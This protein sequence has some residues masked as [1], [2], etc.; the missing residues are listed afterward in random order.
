MKLKQV[1]IQAACAALALGTATVAFAGTQPNPSPASPV[2]VGGGASLPEFLYSSEIAVFGPNH[3]YAVTGSGGGKTALTTNNP[4]AFNAAYVTPRTDTTV[5]YAGSDSILSSSDISAFAPRK[6]TDGALVQIPSVGTAVGIPFQN[7]SLSSLTLNDDQLC[8]VFSGQIT[9][10]AA[11]GGASGP[12][13]VV[14]RSDSSGTSEIFTRHL[15]AVCNANNSNVTFVTSTKFTD[16]F[17]GGVPSNFVGGNLSAGVRD[18]VAANSGI[19]YLSPDYINTTLAPNSTVATKNLSAASLTNSN[20]GQTYDP[21]SANTTTA[22]SNLTLPTL[23]SNLADPNTWALTVANPSTGYP[24][25]GVTYLDHVQCYA[26]ATVLS[27]IQT[28]LDRHTTYSGINSNL[29]R[30]TGN[31]FAPL[32]DALVSL[33][34]DNLLNNVNGKNVNIGNTTACAGKAGR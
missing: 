19:G 14:Y 28:F 22:L 10:W 15:A 33:I 13:K 2:V 5:H 3:I 17:P 32:P 11:L 23:S 12:I 9:D 31:G 18:A 6:G 7:A 27:K 26:N 16:S 29:P 24:I 4:A 20:D 21:T 8:G 30:I 1:M 34:R 25:A